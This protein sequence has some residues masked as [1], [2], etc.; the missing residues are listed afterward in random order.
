MT[1]HLAKA[2]V[3]GHRQ[4]SIF[5]RGGLEC[6]F[7]LNDEWFDHQRMEIENDLIAAHVLTTGEVPEA[8]FIG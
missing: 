6:S 2:R 8:Q 3:E 1:A 4:G 5:D 7:V